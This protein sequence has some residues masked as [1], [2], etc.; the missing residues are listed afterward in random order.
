MKVSTRRRLSALALLLT[1]ICSGSTGLSA[2]EEAND[3]AAESRFIRR[4][5]QLTFEGRRAGEGYFSEDGSKLVFQSEREP[6]NPFYQIYLLDL[7]TGETSRISPGQ[8]K[9]TCAFQRAGTDE[10]LFASTH[11]DPRSEEYQRAELELRATGKERRYAWDYDPEMELYVAAGA[12][13]KLTRLTDTRGYD[14][15]G[16]YSPNGEWIVFSSNRDA[17]AGELDPELAERLE[18]DPSYF[19]EIYLM[20]ADGTG[21]RRLTH[22]PGYDGGPFFTAD[23]ERIVWRRFDAGGAIADIW[24]MKLDGTDQR[25]LTRFESMS[26]APY[27]HP[28]GKYILFTSNKL[29]FDNFELFIVDTAGLHQPVRVTFTPGFDGL[30]V[31]S[32][33]GQKLAWTTNRNGESAQIWLAEWD[34]EQALAA[35]REAPPR[36]SAAPGGAGATLSSISEGLTEAGAGP[37]PG[38]DSLLAPTGSRILAYWP[39]R[40]EAGATGAGV[41][42]VTACLEDPGSAAAAAA[43]A[44]GEQL[45]R[46]SLARPVLMAIWSAE[47]NGCP[48]TKDFPSDSAIPLDRIVAAVEIYGL[49]R[50]RENRLVLSGARSSSVWPGLIERTNVV[51]GFDIQVEAG[52]AEESIAA[53]LHAQDIPAI[54]LT[55]DPE[56]SGGS[57]VSA[58]DEDATRTAAFT[59]LLVRKLAAL[60]EPP[61]YSET[62]SGGPPAGARGKGRPFTGTIPDY[63]G[64][65]D[66]LKL[67][68][69]IEG[70]PAALVGLRAG[71]VI[72]E[73]AGARISGIEDYA[74][75]LDGLTIG[76]PV[77]VVFRREGQTMKVE[78][79]PGRRD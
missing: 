2:A 58:T 43:L 76:E 35:L 65:G 59:A 41:V 53:T 27:P 66:G 54:T 73:F 77:E 67:E 21:Q 11:H 49:G 63:A 50:V 64:G 9:T 8:G 42:M 3:A 20:R 47:D 26:W 16:S 40:E 75:A 72:V 23:G 17:Y 62:A 22:E 1:G 56:G 6:G 7:E 51:H 79:T 57:A 4:A 15:E 44:V 10:I 60:D 55:T 30:P 70:G 18:I 45:G 71:D 14:A 32:P 37:P 29:G 39:A 25:R 38:Q 78:I 28:S 33:D 5:R 12:S 61:E 13:G 48:S 36:D 24:S 68:G 31:P 74:R 46:G 19:L 34:H 69:V 52:A